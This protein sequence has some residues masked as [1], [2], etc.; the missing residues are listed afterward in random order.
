MLA[1]KF[2]E[3]FN[4]NSCPGFLKNIMIEINPSALTEMTS[5]EVNWCRSQDLP[6]VMVDHSLTN[7]QIK[8]F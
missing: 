1:Q 6:L 8:D 4:E 7:V 3:S 5:A 2:S